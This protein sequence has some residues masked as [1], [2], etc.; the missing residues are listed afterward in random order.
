MTTVK[1]E[2]LQ[3]LTLDNIEELKR[4]FSL[5]D[6]RETGVLSIQ[7]IKE[8]NLYLFC[9][10]YEDLDHNQTLTLKNYQIKAIFMEVSNS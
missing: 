8:C 10:D 7:Q 3:T 4:V 5:I 9:V 2:L 1:E 6:K